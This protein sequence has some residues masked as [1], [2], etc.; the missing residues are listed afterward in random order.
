MNTHDKD[1][2]EVDNYTAQAVLNTQKK[3]TD[4]NFWE[5][6]AYHPYNKYVDSQ[7]KL[8]KDRYE[9][10]KNMP[11][12]LMIFTFIAVFFNEEKLFLK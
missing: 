11:L 9:S 12:F 4:S 2:H 10:L 1:I 6:K 5:S 8:N 3:N 7:I